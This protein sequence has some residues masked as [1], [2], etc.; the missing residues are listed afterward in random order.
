MHLWGEHQ[1]VAGVL[2][3]NSFSLAQMVLLEE[4][5]RINCTVT[6]TTAASYACIV[7]SYWHLLNW[8]TLDVQVRVKSIFKNLLL[9]I[10]VSNDKFLI[11]K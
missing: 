5:F 8:L 11:K 2:P 4:C 1:V 10:G 7:S 9:T 6:H 3:N